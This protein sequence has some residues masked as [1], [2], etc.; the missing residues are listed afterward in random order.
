MSSVAD[1]HL[2]KAI[3]RSKD[4]A[5][6]P[7]LEAYLGTTSVNTGG[8]T[9]DAI[10]RARN[11]VI[12]R[13]YNSKQVKQELT[14]VITGIKNLLDGLRSVDARL[15]SG[16]P[17]AGRLQPNTTEAVENDR[18][19]YASDDSLSSSSRPSRSWRA[20]PTA[21][22]ASQ[23]GAPL[24]P[25]MKHEVQILQPTGPTSTTF[26]KRNNGDEDD[27]PEWESAMDGEAGNS[28]GMEVESSSSESGSQVAKLLSTTGNSKAKRLTTAVKSTF[29]P[30]LMAGGYWSGSESAEELKDLEPRKN[31]R[32]QRARRAIWEK[33]FGQGANH[34]KQTVP[35]ESWGFRHDVRSQGYSSRQREK[36]GVQGAVLHRDELQR[37]HHTITDRQPT[38]T[39]AKANEDR[40]IHP[41]W[42]AARQAKAQKQSAAF[43]GKKI[44]FD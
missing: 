24:S 6:S 21:S 41:S 40:P 8:T 10:A 20:D 18:E 4:M 30:S 16:L 5:A 29:L 32:G 42:E 19:L 31:R 35:E 17:G 38:K 37:E 39:S 9:E 36:T 3:L 25:A 2:R 26:A 22:H 15:A 28:V 7:A 43:K 1:A 44:V 13:L 11:N 33:K 34:L 14:T 27:M 23:N 12:A